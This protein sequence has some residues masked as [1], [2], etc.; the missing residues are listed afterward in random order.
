MGI[1]SWVILGVVV[2]FTADA[3]LPGRAPGGAAATAI[4]GI[5]GALIGGISA[6]VAGLGG[7]GDLFDPETWL[8]A[9]VATLLLL[10]N[11]RAIPGR[12][13]P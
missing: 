4:I 2:A 11:Y 7:I 6:S 13:S 12:S 8:L 10:V 9:V 5:I 1:L 3:I